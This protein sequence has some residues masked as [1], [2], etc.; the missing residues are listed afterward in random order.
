M[1]Q[2]NCESGWR[3]ASPGGR[4]V[5]IRV[6]GRDISAIE[7]E[8]LAAALAVAGIT[9]L[10]HSP[11]AEGPRGVFCLMGSCQECLVHADGAPELACMLPV[12]DGMDVKL[13]RLVRE[14]RQ[15]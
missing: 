12:R 2:S 4:A 11:V 15:C 1:I 14:R 13:D 3:R 9:I 10:R 7:G 8:S 5:H 6:D